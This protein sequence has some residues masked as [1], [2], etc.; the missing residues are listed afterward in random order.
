MHCTYLVHNHTKFKMLGDK[1]P[2]SFVM[3]CAFVV[4]I[5]TFGK[6]VDANTNIHMYCTH[7]HTLIHTHTF[8]ETVKHKHTRYTVA[9]KGHALKD[10]ETSA[11]CKIYQHNQSQ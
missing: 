11:I 10:F 1:A 2:K 6:Y 7:K 5:L 4:A 8:I 9:H 3:L